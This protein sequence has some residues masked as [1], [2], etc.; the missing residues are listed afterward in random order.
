VRPDGDTPEDGNERHGDEQGEEEGGYEG[1]ESRYSLI[2][3][4]D[5]I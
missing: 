2:S 1:H 4:D 3:T 5:A